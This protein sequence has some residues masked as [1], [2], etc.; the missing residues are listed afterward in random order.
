MSIVSWSSEK[1][2]MS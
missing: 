1:R 2:K